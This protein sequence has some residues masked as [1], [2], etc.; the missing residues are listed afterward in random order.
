MKVT[1]TS[2]P[3]QRSGTPFSQSESAHCPGNAGIHA[4]SSS[5]CT[6]CTNSYCTSYDEI[7]PGPVDGDVTLTTPTGHASWMHSHFKWY[8]LDFRKNSTLNDYNRSSFERF[9]DRGDGCP[10]WRA[11]GG[12]IYCE[13]G[14]YW[15]LLYH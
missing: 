14:E 6:G 8:G 11:L 13:K 4:I 2:L 10:Q 9:G 7:L 15:D 12:N 5:S 1:I 3:L